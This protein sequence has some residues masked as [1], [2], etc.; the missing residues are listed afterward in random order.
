MGT[1][2]KLVLCIALLTIS[3]HLM[4][5]PL[6]S[7]AQSAGPS[8][9]PEAQRA[10]GRGMDAF[11]QQEWGL[12]A[13]YFAEAQKMAPWSVPVIF[14]L[15]L[16]HAR[17]GHEPAGIAW[18]YAYLAAAPQAQNA[19]VVRGEI[20]R[21]KAATRRK[22]EQ[23][24]QQA[25]N[26]AK[27]LGGAEGSREEARKNQ[28]LSSVCSRQAAAGDFE[29]AR[30]TAKMGKPGCDALREY[31]GALRKAKDLPAAQDLLSRV[32]APAERDSVLEV[33]S[34]L[35][36][37]SGDVEAARKAAGQI[38]DLAKK[39]NA[40]RGIRIKDLKDIIERNNARGDFDPVPVA[41][42]RPLLTQEKGDALLTGIIQAQF[43]FKEFGRARQTIDQLWDVKRKV[44]E[45][46]RLAMAELE[47]GDAA[48]AKAV[49]KDI[50]RLGVKMK[51]ADSRDALPVA[52]AILGEHI[53]AVSAAVAVQESVGAGGALAFLEAMGNVAFVQAV[54]G[55]LTG[56]KRTTEL[57]VSLIKEQVWKDTAE[58]Y[59]RSRIAQAQLARGQ[60]GEALK[61]VETIPD[62]QDVL[63]SG[64]RRRVLAQAA[65]AQ[66][67]AGDLSGAERTLGSIRTPGLDPSSTREK[68]D[69]MLSLAQAYA[70]RQS[71]SEAR[72]ILAAATEVAIQATPPDWAH[73]EKIADA[74][75]RLGDHTGWAKT[76]AYGLPAAA[77]EWVKLASEISGLSSVVSLDEALEKAGKAKAEDLPLSLSLVAQELGEQLLR[78]EAL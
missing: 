69:L 54:S 46:A 53:N 29:G 28:A 47:A 35:F 22:M 44:R 18:L 63:T 64:Y 25:I 49:A 31:L 36:L 41:E 23:I 77:Q 14:N 34:S 58:N 33:M 19:D 61:T 4:L 26:A 9:P 42:L 43:K 67:K 70:Q 10:F 62:S 78:I 30:A 57:A 45:L 5:P 73:L 68:L 56:A 3:I 2:M 66:I 15:G 60:I 52:E 74:Q 76:R 1:R 12:A 71:G 27:Q 75:E 17:G 24:F 32:S 16:A 38:Q 11:Q 72:R 7:H 50:Q 8:V 37:E 13:R 39:G 59:A 55:D 40:L 6:M 20:G 48:G 21:L 65:Q 51:P